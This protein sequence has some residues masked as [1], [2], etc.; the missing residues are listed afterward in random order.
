MSRSK[1]LEFEKPDDR[2]LRRGRWLEPAVRLAVAEKF[3]QWNIVP[4]GVYLRA[5]ELRLGAT[6]D[7]FIEGDPR[8]LGILQCKTVAPSVFIREWHEGTECPF[9]S[10]LQALTEMMLSDAAFGVV[11]GLLVDPHQ[12][13]VCTIDVPHNATAEAKI[14]A[15]VEKFWRDVEQGNE[16]DP[17]YGKDAAVI[18]ALTAK[19][20]PGKAVDLSGHNELRELLELRA[21][22]MQQIKRND[23][24]CE[25]IEGQLRL[26]LRDAEY[27][28]GLP[29]WRITYK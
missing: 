24:R 21:A 15:A 9:W 12:M 22:L 29:D 5:P 26:L 2:V 16:P 4:A 28:T 14:I 10:V 18:R 11:A 6:P 7:F 25:E 19:E 1:A 13:D 23:D 20:V 17:D 27:V 3:P 8:G